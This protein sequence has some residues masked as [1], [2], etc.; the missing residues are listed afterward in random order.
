MIQGLS[1][2][3]FSRTSAISLI[4]IKNKKEIKKER[5]IDMAGIRFNEGKNYACILFS[6]FLSGNPHIQYYFDFDLIFSFEDVCSFFLCI[7]RIYP[8]NTGRWMTDYIVLYICSRC[9]IIF[10]MY[11]VYLLFFFKGTVY[12]D[13]LYCDLLIMWPS[14]KMFLSFVRSVDSLLR[15]CDN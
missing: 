14:V 10:I 9:N 3:I 12:T 6:F 11:L 13:I 8:L 1:Y 2:Q 15:S 7:C 4:K 5:R